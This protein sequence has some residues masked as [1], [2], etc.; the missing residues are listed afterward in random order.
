VRIA[1]RL[2]LPA[3]TVHAVL[4]RCHIICAEEKAATAIAVLQRAVTWFAD[5]GVTVE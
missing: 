2:A 1:G 4:T 5:R 3:S